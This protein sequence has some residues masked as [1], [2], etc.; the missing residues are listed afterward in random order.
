MAGIGFF[1]TSP[2]QSTAIRIPTDPA[3]EPRPILRFVLV[4]F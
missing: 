2:Q 4:L 3:I 1:R